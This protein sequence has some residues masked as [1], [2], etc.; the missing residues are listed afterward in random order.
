[1]YNL[2]RIKPNKKG[3]IELSIGTVVIIVLAMT[4]LILGLVLVRNIFGGATDS[5]TSLNDKVKAEITNLF[6]EESSKIGI[7]LGAAKIAKV[8]AGTTNFGIAVGARTE[9]NGDVT[10]TNPLKYRLKLTNADCTTINTIFTDPT[11]ASSAVD[12]MTD[13]ADFDDIVGPNGYSIFL[14]DVPKGTAECTQKV[15]II[16]YS[17]ANCAATGEIEKSTFRIQVIAGGIFS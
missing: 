1:M 2:R 8:K 10:T 13:C 16:T 12:T 14:M 5:V 9:D 6:T 7:K 11:F 3:A 4:M 15:Q 17:D